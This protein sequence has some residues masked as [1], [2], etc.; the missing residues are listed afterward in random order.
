MSQAFA[1]LADYTSGCV[2]ELEWRTKQVFA[3]RL[4]TVLVSCDASLGMRY[5]LA[6]GIDSPSE[7]YT[8]MMRN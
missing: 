1:E 6:A 4:Y 8:P 5:P 2:E 7:Q 3:M